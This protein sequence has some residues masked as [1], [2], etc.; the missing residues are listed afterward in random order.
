LPLKLSDVVDTWR[1]V[2]TTS[3]RTAKIDRIASLLSSASPAEAAI[4][5]AWL[6]GE[7][8]QGRIGVGWA[9][10]Q[11]AGDVSTSTGPSPGVDEVD[12]T[13]SEIAAASG[14]GSTM[15]RGQLLRDLFARS[16]ADE[17]EFVSRLLIG[18]LRQGALD[19]LMT[20]AIARGAAVAPT[21][22]RRALLYS[23]S[24]PDVARIALESG[25]DGLDA[26][27]LKL[28]TPLQPMLA[29]TADDVGGAL[30]RLG[31]AGLEYKLDGAR[32]QVHRHGD[33]VRIFTR[34]LN[35]VT[36][37]LPD[38]VACVLDLPS[39]ELI[40]DG[41]AIA[42]RP[43]GRPLPFQTTMARFG[44]RKDVEGLRESLPLSCFFFDVLRA[45]GQ[46]MIDRPAAER[47]GALE[48]LVPPSMRVRRIIT[49]D[50]DAAAEFLRNACR[51]GHEGVIAKAL[52]ARYDAGARGSAWLKIK[53][54]HTL[55]LVVL[56]A[57][58][59][60]GRR[61]G[62]LS[63]LHLGARSPDGFVMLGKTFK[64]LTDRTLEWQTKELLARKTS[65]SGHVV[66]VR[67][68]LVVEIAFNDLQKSSRYPGGL[69]LRFARV[70]AYRT[71]RSAADAD[72]IETVR[73]IYA[74]QLGEAEGTTRE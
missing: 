31:E 20:D 56:A 62:W 65:R 10:V 48:D 50:P 22:V 53:P 67:P 49:G 34:N 47:F 72:T 8:R 23:G 74:G 28:F 26:F 58:W 14:R 21:A 54:V 46:T 17:R 41:E 27:G 30:D 61:R 25:T 5:A 69:A 59:G 36:E 11:S 71:D 70:R 13:F 35:D 16:T 66:H 4:V 29:Q 7:L 55:D 1:D 32:I 42:L 38:I 57:E 64:G 51:T 73:A 44:R 40:L 33:D 63:N 3:S 45:D 9:T 37:S 52:D 12:A 18:E 6:A 43:D 68:E 60:H 39:R 24:I 19:G 15:R 2:G